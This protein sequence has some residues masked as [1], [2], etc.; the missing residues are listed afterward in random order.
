[1]TKL[2]KLEHPLQPHEAQQHEGS[3]ADAS[4][5][6]TTQPQS[7]SLY[8]VA[9][10]AMLL[11]CTGR[12][13]FVTANNFIGFSSKDIQVGDEV[14][15]LSGIGVPFVLRQVL[16]DR[17]VK[18]ENTEDEELLQA[19]RLIDEDDLKLYRMVGESYI[20][21]FMQ[22]QLSARDDDEWEGICVC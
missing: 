22:G 4:S 3:S 12:R 16:A 18:G 21:G 5:S 20:H 17:Q 9:L 2:Y 10:E 11:A 15:V 6:N 8:T 7:F 19:M 13:L 14:H 1:M